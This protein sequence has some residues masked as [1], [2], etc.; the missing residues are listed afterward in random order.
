MKKAKDCI[1]YFVFSIEAWMQTTKYNQE[2]YTLCGHSLGGYLSSYYSIKFPT[3]LNKL[4][5]LS[6]VGVPRAP[7][8]FNA[9]KVAQDCDSAAGAFLFRRIG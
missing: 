7:P 5:L 2:N 1:D 8:D 4:V 3:N 9:E 6:P